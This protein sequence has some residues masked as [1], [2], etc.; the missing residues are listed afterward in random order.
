MLRYHAAMLTPRATAGVAALVVLALVACTRAPEHA[1]LPRG[2]TILALGDS[3]TYGTGADAQA[4]YP[5]VLATLTG[6]QVENAGVPG[7]TSAQICARLPEHLEA[8]RPALVLVLAGGNDFLRRLP[9]QGIRDALRAC[10]SHARAQG[11]P[12]ALMPVPRLGW[13]GLGDATLYRE[14][15][16]ELRVPLVDA[17]LAELIGRPEMRSDAVH[18]N[19]AGYRALAHNV[20]ASLAQLGWLRRD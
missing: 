14:A 5:A 17:G 7:E 12:L 16:D 19:A 2:A 20:A 10:A 3:L 15:A 11:V 8:Q 6:W 9:E 18:L 1:P 4:A 13:S